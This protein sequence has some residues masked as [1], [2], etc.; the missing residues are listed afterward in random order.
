MDNGLWSRTIYRD[1]AQQHEP[2]EVRRSP[3]ETSCLVFPPGLRTDGRRP[4]FCRRDTFLV[5]AF[6]WMVVRI[7]TDNP[8]YWACAYPSVFVFTSDVGC[9]VDCWPISPDPPSHLPIIV[10]FIVMLHVRAPF[11]IDVR[12]THLNCS[13]GQGIWLP[14][15]C[16]RWRSSLQNSSH[17]RSRTILCDSARWR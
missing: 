6:S 4:T 16:S 2:D 9:S 12:K 3:L 7:I 14:A 8:G 15:V 17:L 5:P 1:S 13:P 10:Q 11:Q